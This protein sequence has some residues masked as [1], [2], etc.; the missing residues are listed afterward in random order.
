M[1][2]PCIC[3]RLGLLGACYECTKIVELTPIKWC[4]QGACENGAFFKDCVLEHACPA[5]DVNEVF[6]PNKSTFLLAGDANSRKQQEHLAGYQPLVAF[7][8]FTPSEEMGGM[9]GTVPRMIAKQ[10]ERGL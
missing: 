5:T 6:S 4:P 1:H 9:M 2:S 3:F 8:P 10:L 7:P